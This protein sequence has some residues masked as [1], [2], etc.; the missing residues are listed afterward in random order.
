MYRPNMCCEVEPEKMDVEKAV[1]GAECCVNIV[2][3]C[4][5]CPY[6]KT[7]DGICQN[8]NA[9]IIDLHNIAKK[10]QRIIEQLRSDKKNALEKLKRMRD[11][12]G[13]ILLSTR[14]DLFP[15][16]YNRNS[17]LYDGLQKAVSVLEEYADKDDE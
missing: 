8:N 13:R 2:P 1:K 6:P 5:R 3:D 14:R 7:A 12:N 4:D 15:G 11:F 10:Q 16:S 17:G 9:V